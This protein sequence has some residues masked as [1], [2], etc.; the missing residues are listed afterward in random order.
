ML[1]ATI[2]LRYATPALHAFSL[3]IDAAMPYAIYADIFTVRHYHWRLYSGYMITMPPF[4]SPLITLSQ[5]YVMSRFYAAIITPALSIF[6][7]AIMITLS[8]PYAFHMMH[9]ALF[10]AADFMM[11]I[12]H[13][14]ATFSS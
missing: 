2:A 6:F 8:A 9:F 11:S 7:A 13:G 14:Y 1:S 12:F 10:F 4:F 3:L 5:R